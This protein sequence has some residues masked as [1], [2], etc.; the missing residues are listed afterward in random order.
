M[1]AIG[2]LDASLSLWGMG[3]DHLHTQLLKSSLDLGRALALG[4]VDSV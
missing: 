2:T 1:G 3:I 4:I